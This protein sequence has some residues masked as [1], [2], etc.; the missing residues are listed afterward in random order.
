MICTDL[1]SLLVQVLF[2]HL[3]EPLEQDAGGQG[4]WTVW[5]GALPRCASL[6][7]VQAGVTALREAGASLP[8]VPSSQVVNPLPLPVH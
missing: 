7:G 3:P 2:E 6:G 4:P 8:H 5:Q 1:H